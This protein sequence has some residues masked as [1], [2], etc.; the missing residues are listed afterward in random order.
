MQLYRKIGQECKSVFQCVNNI[1]LENPPAAKLK[2]LQTAFD[3]PPSRFSQ[4]CWKILTKCFTC[5]SFDIVNK[6]AMNLKL[7]LTPGPHSHQLGE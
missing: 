1:S 2:F 7:D 4:M 6:L 5:V 3:S